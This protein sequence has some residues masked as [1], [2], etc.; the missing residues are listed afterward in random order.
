MEKIKFIVI[1]IMQLIVLL[2]IFND[3]NIVIVI[4]YNV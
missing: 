1:N 3:K 4:K 2:I